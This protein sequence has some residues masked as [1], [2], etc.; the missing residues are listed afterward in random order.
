M[1]LTPSWNIFYRDTGTP[2]SLETESALQA[3]SI[4]NALTGAIT[5]SRA[6]QTFRWANSTERAAQA[7]MVAGDIGIQVDNMVSYRYSGT[8]WAAWES[9]WTTYNTTLLDLSIGTGGAAS[10]LT[11]YRYE[12]GRIRVSFRFV[13]G[14][15][16]ASI[17]ATPRF[18]LPMPATP[19][20]HGNAAYVWGSLGGTVFDSSTSVA[21]LLVPLSAGTSTTE[22]R[23][24]YLDNTAGILAGVATSAPWVWAAS[25][26]IQGELIYDPA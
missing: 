14:T 7:G 9:N 1:P 16:G 13:L 17:G 6:I 25:D 20:P 2:A 24:F 11:R 18:T 10:M 23:L 21:R 8:A 26:A 3:T 12:Q 4:E 19:P 5:D 15:S 22:V